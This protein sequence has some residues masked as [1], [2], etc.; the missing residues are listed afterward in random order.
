MTPEKSGFFMKTKRAP[1]I[2]II[3]GALSTTILL[4]EGCANGPKYGASKKHSKSC[5]CPHWNALPKRTH[6]VWGMKEENDR[7][8][9]TRN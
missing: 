3:L 2:M 9:G 4:S 8:H 1:L 5:D 6:Q 7:Q